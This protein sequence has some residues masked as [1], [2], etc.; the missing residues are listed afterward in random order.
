MIVRV[1]IRNVL[2]SAWTPTQRKKNRSQLSGVSIL[3]I[4]LAVLLA[5]CGDQGASGIGQ[6]PSGGIEQDPAGG[7]EQEPTDDAEQDPA[8]D[9]G[10]EPT[11]DVGR[12]PTGEEEELPPIIPDTT[13][14]VEGP[15]MQS[16]EE[17]SP[18]GTFTF[19]ASVQAEAFLA[20]VQEG[21]VLA[22]DVTELAPGGF[23]RKVLS[24]NRS[25]NQFVIETDETTLEEAVQQGVVEIGE[26]LTTDDLAVV[27]PAKK[28]IAVAKVRPGRAPGVIRIEIP[29]VELADKVFANGSIEVEPK[30][31]FKLVVKNHQ[32]EEVHFTNETKT[33]VDL[34]LD[35]QL[36]H[37]GVES[38]KELASMRFKPITFWVGVLPVVIQ[39]ELVL[40]VGVNGDV[41]ADI[42]TSVVHYGELSSGVHYDKVTNWTTQ[43]TDL[44]NTHEFNPPHL[45]TD[46]SLKAFA[47]PRLNLFLY[48]VLGP[49]G[50]LDGYLELTAD[51]LETPWWEFYG[52][53]EAG[54]GVEVKILG[55]A[56]LSYSAEVLDERWLIEDAGGPISADPPPTTQEPLGGLMAHYAFA[57]NAN[58]QSGNGNHG[59][60]SGA[61]LATDRHGTID[62]AYGF[63]GQADSIG[64]P[65]DESL[66][67]AEQISLVAWVLPLSQ[68][69]QEIVRKGAEV[70]GP[71]ATPYALAL[72]GT[73]DVVFSLRPD[74]QFTQLRKTGYPL[75]EWFFV[76]GTYDGTTMKLYINGNLE[77]SSAIAGVLNENSSPLLIG[78]RLNLPADT[79]HG[80]IDEV[81]IYDRALSEAEVAALYT[82]LSS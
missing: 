76:V 68:K 34:E 26:E 25:G 20:N 21:D 14:V 78:T 47:G 24:V 5:A 65:D 19:S 43:P 32:I 73:G 82:E 70:N 42:T 48:G 28:G 11:D 45:T 75:G 64:V 71:T 57:G 3:L 12:E 16:L 7:V 22:S 79:F 74:L 40:T 58:D 9:V 62:S 80:A 46:A 8:D 1:T 10:R 55:L 31:N 69:T 72:S 61:Q 30:F 29:N 67:V 50:Q 63:D 38:R 59:T 54:I 23:L 2:A 36:G 44:T 51:V 39:P 27:L 18:E 49:H 17:I 6:A 41:S 52:G 60:V 81:R 56:L 33:M 4:L 15:T 53:L 37:A 66:H 77:N 35:A 13:K